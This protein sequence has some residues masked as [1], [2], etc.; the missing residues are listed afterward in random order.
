MAASVTKS[1][2]RLEKQLLIKDEPFKTAI[3]REKNKV[4]ILM[5]RI[6]MCEVALKSQFLHWE[7]W[8]FVAGIAFFFLQKIYIFLLMCAE[9][10][11]NEKKKA[12]TMDWHVEIQNVAGKTFN[13]FKP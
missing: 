12:K 9:C 11:A 1:K 10:H 6:N 2:Y 5:Q 13:F 4:Y 7:P 3:Y 8:I